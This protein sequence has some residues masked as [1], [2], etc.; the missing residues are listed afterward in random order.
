MGDT[1]VWFAGGNDSMWMQKR[2]GRNCGRGA[3]RVWVRMGLE[4][5][6]RACPQAAGAL[7]DWQ[8]E[9]RWRGELDFRWEPA[10]FLLLYL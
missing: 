3:S 2:R 6:E 5:L 9:Q 8:Q 1:K 7:A 4:Q 10:R